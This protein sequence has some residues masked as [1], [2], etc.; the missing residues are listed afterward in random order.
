MGQGIFCSDLKA[1]DFEGDKILISKQQ[2]HSAFGYLIK[3][4]NNIIGKV[5]LKSK[6]FK[7]PE[8]ILVFN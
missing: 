7:Y 3:Q 5:Y 4:N 2:K 8:F 1:V 6:I